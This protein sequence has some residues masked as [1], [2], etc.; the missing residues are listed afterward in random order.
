M[1]V[2]NMDT[3]K[4]R[5]GQGYD[6]HRLVAGREFILGGVTIPAEKGEDAHSDG[7]VLLHA[8]I[9]SLFGAAA[10]GDIGTH[11]PPTD[12]QYK[13]ISSRDLLREAAARVAEMGWTV[14]N[15]DATVILEKPKI[16]TYIQE[17]R[18]NIAE[19]LKIGKDWVSVKGKTSEK[20]GPVGNGEAVEAQAV[21][22]IQN[23]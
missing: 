15:I 7:D 5:V 13:N 20:T 11:F 18:N 6:I 22:L 23:R 4:I 21:C 12:D 17:M 9:D 16:R 8:V 3:G 2:D 10:A 14:V 19:D 1:K